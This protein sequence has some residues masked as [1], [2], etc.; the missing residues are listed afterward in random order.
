MNEVDDVVLKG[1]PILLVFSF[2]DIIVLL[3]EV[4][5]AS[6]RFLIS[7]FVLDDPS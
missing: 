3:V 5:R 2:L 1:A 6:L 4:S 7:L